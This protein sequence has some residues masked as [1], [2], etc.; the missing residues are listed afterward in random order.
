M[1]RDTLYIAFDSDWQF[2]LQLV[3]SIDIHHPK[4]GE[5][6]ENE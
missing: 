1:V 6:E 5:E 4:L 2:Q 3:D